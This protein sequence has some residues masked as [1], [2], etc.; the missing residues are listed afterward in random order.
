MDLFASNATKKYLRDIM[1]GYKLYL[2][3]S[4]V[5]LIQVP[6]YKWLKVWDI[7]TF[8]QTK[9]TLVDTFLIMSIKRNLIEHGYAM[10]LT[11]LYPM[12]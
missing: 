9:C 1:R 8:A 2:K 7:I 3:S 12:T 10:L 6:Q 11:L 5:M 4:D